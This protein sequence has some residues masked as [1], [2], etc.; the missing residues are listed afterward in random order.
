MRLDEFA[1]QSR[2]LSWNE[3]DTYN[4]SLAITFEEFCGLQPISSDKFDSEQFEIPIFVIEDKE[5]TTSILATKSKILL[6][7]LIELW[8]E[9]ENHIVRIH[10]KGSG[11]YTKYTVEGTEYLYDKASSKIRKIPAKKKG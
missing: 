2:Y 4:I 1:T 7:S 9:K 8:N 11:F 5:A 10:K 6:N 3:S